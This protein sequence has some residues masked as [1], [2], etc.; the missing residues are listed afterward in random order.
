MTLAAE[1]DMKKIMFNDQYCLTKAVLEGRKTQTRRI[2]PQSVIDM[3]E[4]YRA[5]YYKDTFDS[6]SHEEN[7]IDAQYLVGH[8]RY[9]V[10]EEI[11]IA[12]AYKDCYR[13][14]CLR[15]TAGWDNKMFVNA[16]YM[17][18]RIL[19]TN[20]R[21]ERLQDISDKDCMLEGI[22]RV[23]KCIGY[24]K[25]ESN[26]GLSFY[27]AATYREAFAKLIDKVSGKGTWESNPLV[28]VYD[29]VLVK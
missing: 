1:D 10:G 21:V 7:L 9:A 5:E 17:P 20:I 28:F 12:Q 24:W 23:D 3:A 11:A 2:I 15:D 29:F 4:E 13:V 27:D 18:H 14:V 22:D 6:I 26:G 16:I 8:S 19:I 25:Q